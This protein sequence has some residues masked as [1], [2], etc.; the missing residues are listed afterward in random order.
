[1]IDWAIIP[2]SRSVDEQERKMVRYTKVYRRF[3]LLL[4]GI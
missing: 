3:L 2:R 1:M 4:K